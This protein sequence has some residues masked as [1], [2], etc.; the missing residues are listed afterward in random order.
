MGRHGETEPSAAQAA[1]D[2]PAGRNSREIAIWTALTRQH[3][4][5]RFNKTIPK[6]R[7]GAFRLTSP[8][9]L[10]R[11]VREF[12]RAQPATESCGSSGRIRPR[13]A[14]PPGPARA[15]P[16]E[17]RPPRCRLHSPTRGLPA[18]HAYPAPAPA[19]AAR[20]PPAPRVASPRR[21]HRGSDAGAAAASPSR[22]RPA[23]PTPAPSPPGPPRPRLG[24][25]P[26]PPAARPLGRAGRGLCLGSAT[27]RLVSPSPFHRGENLTFRERTRH[28]DLGC[29]VLQDLM[30]YIRSEST[31]D[32]QTCAWKSLCMS[33]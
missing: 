10:A 29:K 31:R 25:R 3:G 27:Q 32:F 16:G 13:A 26:V 17:L 30:A 2:L 24:P 7:A 15:N 9:S 14:G 28:L 18:Q 11:T 12:C 22:R 4:G 6:T 20:P 23:R 21:R 5:G 8:P 33:V 19:R 1:W